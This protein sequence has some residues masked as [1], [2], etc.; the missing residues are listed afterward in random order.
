MVKDSVKYLGNLDELLVICLKH[1]KDVP[2]SLTSNLWL[3]FDFMI[4][5]NNQ[6]STTYKKTHLD[7]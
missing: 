5:R 6:I 4:I 7:W 2:L 3:Q 1:L